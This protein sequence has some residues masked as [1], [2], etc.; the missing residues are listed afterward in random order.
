MSAPDAIPENAE[1]FS[2]RDRER[3]KEKLRKLLPHTLTDEN[4]EGLE[5]IA[6]GVRIKIE[7]ERAKK[8]ADDAIVSGLKILDPDLIRMHNVCEPDC[9]PR[10]LDDGGE[11]EF[12]DFDWDWDE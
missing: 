11:F 4:K 5:K 2:G 12:D 9:W 1:S 6:S 7:A 3:L 10:L 8:E